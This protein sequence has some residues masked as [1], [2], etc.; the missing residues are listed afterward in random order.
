MN[1]LDLDCRHVWHPF[2][3]AQ[4]APDPIPIASAQ[5]IRLYAED[6]REFLDLISSWWVNIHGHAHPTIAAAIAR[7]AHT[8]EQVIFAGFTHQP[9]AQLAY[10]LVQR[11]PVG[12]TRV[13]FSDDGSTAVEVALKMALQYWRNHGET[14]RTRFLAF[15]GGY[16][17]D[18]VGAMSAG[19]GCGFFDTYG[20]LLF[21]V[22][23]LPFP[24][25]WDG[26][27]AVAAKEKA[28]L[29]Q[30]E[31]YL[32]EHGDTLAAV[33]M[34]PLVQGSAGMRM[35]R[36]EFLQALAARL[37]KAGI[38]LIFDEV[39]TGFGRTGDMFASL[40]AQVTPDI[41]C[42]SKGLTAGFL[43]MS[44]TVASEAI[45]AAFLG[46][47]FDRALVHG[48]SFTANSLGCAAALASLQVFADEQTLAK[49][50]QI[51]R[52][53]RQGLATLVGHPLVQRVRVTGTIAAFD[54]VTEDAG[55]TSAIG[56]QL[57]AFFHERGLLLRP[58]GNVVYVL[59]PYCVT[60]AEL[61][62]AYDVILEG[63]NSL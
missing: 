10:E 59:P 60:E 24:A 12:L 21:E 18:T 32:A 17:G 58:L 2:T 39:M 56:A 45:Y 5:G 20:S 53:Q 6:G 55:Y 14:Q 1:I 57:K 43:P 22:G 27:T 48:H 9:A 40:K 16:H 15:E 38:L 51:E 54:V 29:A 37:R 19:K 30:L 50:P 13:F 7:Q 11:L 8:L 49:L 62:Q 42:L 28:A 41:I 36:P 31:R 25:T 35:C 34:E 47:S 52:W 23:L 33:I 46:E 4:T 3:Q 44:V 61:K 26:D 63:L